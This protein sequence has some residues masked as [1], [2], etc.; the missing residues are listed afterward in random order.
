MKMN[1]VLALILVITG[2]TFCA[3]GLIFLNVEI[4]QEPFSY[5]TDLR[6]AGMFQYFGIVCLLGAIIYLLMEMF[7]NHI[8]NLRNVAVI[9]TLLLANLAS[10]FY[11]GYHIRLPIFF[12]FGLIIASIICAWT[13]L[14]SKTRDLVFFA[15]IAMIASAIDEYAHTSVGT[16]TYLDNAVPS[17]LTVFGW[18]IFMIGIVNVSKLAMNLRFL[19]I[20][21]HKVLRLLPAVI[22]L[23]L[24]TIV[25]VLRGYVS[26]FDWVLLI[27]Y[28][29]EGLLSLYY[30]HKQPLK[31]TVFLMITSLFFGFFMESI[32]RWEGLWSFLYNEPVSLLILFSWPLRT[33]AVN[34]VCMLLKIDISSDHL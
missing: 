12:L 15:V 9:F 30:A 13:T 31:W 14:K 17:L 6:Y 29:V 8:T 26:V 2:C 34:C 16:L 22:T 1:L 3:L 32:G 33:W 25:T 5:W 10:F 27:V 20:Q 21:D 28:V 19:N 23:F 4:L 18:S 7:Q 24:I 11:G